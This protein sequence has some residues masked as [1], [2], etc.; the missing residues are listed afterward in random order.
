MLA[1]KAQLKEAEKIKQFILK[2]NLG[3]P[4]LLPFKEFE[5]MY[6]PLKK[7]VKIPNAEVIEVKI[8][9]PEKP[10]PLTVEKILQG[11][12][13]EEEMQLLPKSQEIVGKIMILEIPRELESKEKLI[14]EAYLNVNKQIETVVKKEHMHE[15][16]F[17]TRKVRILAGKLTKK[18]THLENGVK[19]FLHL[20]KTYFSARSSGERLRIAQQVKKGEE[21]LVM[22]SG[23]GPYPLVLAKNSPAKKIYGIEINPLAHYYAETNIER[24]NLSDKIAIYL[25]DVRK[26][27]PTLKRTFD[28]IIMPLPKT[29]EEFLDIAL[30]K[31]KPKGIIHLYSF[32]NEKDTTLEAKKIKKLCSQLGY[33]IKVLRAV[34]CGQFSPGV[35]RVCFDLKVPSRDL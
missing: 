20:E 31:I 14:A 34:K 30:P 1:V 23:A 24:N 22:F 29:S 27:M 26:V 3:I 17:R 7:K 18:T 4:E 15:G 9:F 6:F 12:L 25:G 33:S 8:H 21:V 35:F 11:K 28:R 32:I 19:I 5:F 16:I 2:S 10:K 13:T